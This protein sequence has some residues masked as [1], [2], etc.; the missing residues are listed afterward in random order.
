MCTKVK[1]IAGQKIKNAQRGFTLIE[2]LVAVLMVGI[3]S[4]VAVPQ[5]QKAIQKTKYAKMLPLMHS[6]VSAQKIYYLQHGEYAT[7]FEALDVDLP[8]TNQASARC[9]GVGWEYDTRYAEDMCIA[10]TKPGGPAMGIRITQALP[11]RD[12]WRYFSRGYHYLFG[13]YQAA[14]PGL[15]CLDSGLNHDLVPVNPPECIGPKKVDNAFGRYYFMTT[16]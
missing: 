5:Y 6:L 12:A 3:L 2:L 9:G 10:I 15:Y 13:S 16:Y 1:N 8:L 7:S 4:A 11:P 14:A